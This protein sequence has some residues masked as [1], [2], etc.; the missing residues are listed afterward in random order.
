MAVTGLKLRDVRRFGRKVE[1][2]AKRFG[3]GLAKTAE[4]VGAIAT[5]IA[6]AINPA[7]GA[8]VATATQAVSKFGRS[9]ERI[10]GKGVGKA[11]D[12]FKQAQQPILAGR[13][14]VREAKGAI[15]NPKEAEMRIGETLVNRGLKRAKPSIQR[16]SQQAPYGDWAELP[17]AEGM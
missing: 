6:T 5:P 14:L 16:D 4:V 13:E 15:R 10:A 12:T 7:L 9:T 2:G 1:R 11:L 17:F 8:E 3:R